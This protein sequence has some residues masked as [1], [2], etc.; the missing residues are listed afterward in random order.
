MLRVRDGLELIFI[1]CVYALQAVARSE[2][3]AAAA[4]TAL[5]AVQQL[6]AQERAKAV[7]RPARRLL[8]LVPLRRGQWREASAV[9][10]GPAP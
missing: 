9:R 2:D 1:W 8:P 4:G 10:P 5:V 6:L 7:A 3:E